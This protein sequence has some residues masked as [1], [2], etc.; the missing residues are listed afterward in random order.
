MTADHIRA[1]EIKRAETLGQL[2]GIVDVVIIAKD[3]PDFFDVAEKIEIMRAY[4]AEYTE[5]CNAYLDA[6][7]EIGAAL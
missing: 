7:L 2:L 6:R 1:L 5:A 3:I 4:R